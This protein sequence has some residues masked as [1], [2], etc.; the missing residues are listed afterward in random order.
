MAGYLHDYSMSNNAYDAYEE[1]LAP[2]SKWTKQMILAMVD[3]YDE[4]KT[5]ARKLEAYPLGF[6]KSLFLRCKEWHHTSC[7]YNKTDFWEVDEYRVEGYVEDASDLAQKYEE[8]RTK[9]AEEKAKKDAEKPAKLRHGNLKYYVWNGS[10]RWGRYIPQTVK[11][12]WV[13]QEGN[14]LVAYDGRGKN[15]EVVTKRQIGGCAKPTFE[16]TPVTKKSNI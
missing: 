13:R 7:R 9:Q 4:T 10:R 11:D 8:W 16:P 15:A 1:G 12:V 5:L 3:E 14:W 6:L 2:L